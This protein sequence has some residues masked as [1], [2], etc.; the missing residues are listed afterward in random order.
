MRRKNL[1]GLFFGILTVL[2][3]GQI[4]S[5][6][7]FGQSENPRVA[8][9]AEPTNTANN[10]SVSTASTGNRVDELK[11]LIGIQRTEIE[12]LQSALDK[13]QRELEQMM[14]SRTAQSRT[15]VAAA[16]APAATQQLAGGQEK[17]NDIELLKSE[18]EAVADSAAQANT[19]ITKIET[20]TT[21]Y[22]KSNDAKV[23]QI[24]AFSFGGD[25]RG[26]FEPFFQ[27]GSPDR[28]RERMRLRFNVTGKFSDEFSG[29]FSL[30]TG[31]LDDP[32]STNQTFTGFLNRKS[33]GLDKAWIT[34]KPTYAKFLK[35]DIG[36]FAFPWYRTPMTFDS[37]V[38]PE[39]FAQTLSFDLKS[40]VFRNLTFVGFQLPIT[41]A[42]TGIDSFILGGQIQTQYQFGSKAHLALY[43]AGINFLRTDPLGQAAAA[44]TSGTLVG[45]L[46]N[47]NTLRRSGSTVLGYGYKFAYLDAIMKLDLA[48]SN[49]FPTTILFNFVNNTRGPKERSGYWTEVTVGRNKEEK[50]VQ[51]NYTFTR[52]EK[53]AVISAFNESDLRA[54]T[55]VAQNKFQVAYMF[56]TAVTGSFTAWVGKLAN[57]LMNT[58]QVPSGVRS[59]C[60]GSNVS[61][62]RDPY[63]KRLQFDIVYKF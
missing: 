18:L 19:R 48:T 53:D 17:L 24:G 52:I 9:A 44:R 37:D 43:G 8:L 60:T 15:Q 50:D 61:G 2:L 7:A 46:N 59:A 38:N 3:A 41:E 35:L 51:F 39:G 62:C 28:N 49:R 55:N 36:K 21:A 57:P 14:N 22:T 54:S 29:G 47:F 58:D 12:K 63:L 6:Q 45:S 31:T 40:P 25:F 30:A 26:R 10:A 13:Q 11:Q 34:Y 27:E 42:S 33:I 56:K 23:K 1:F 16:A 5:L 20:D 32:V 4:Q